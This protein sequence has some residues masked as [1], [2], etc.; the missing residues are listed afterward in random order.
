MVGAVEKLALLAFGE[1][2][3]RCRDA[4]IEVLGDSVEPRSVVRAVV[5]PGLED[6]FDRFRG[7][8]ND[9]ILVD[10]LGLAEALTLR[11]GPMRAVKR[12]ASGLDFGKLKVAV[13][14]AKGGRKLEDEPVFTTVTRLAECARR[15][16]VR[17]EL[18]VGRRVGNNDFE[19]AVGLL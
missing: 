15:T 19:C 2:L 12:E 11:A 6:V 14:V 13:G 1:L 3:E 17:I 7:I 10:F 9:E 5:T 4:H 18:E 16:D 8:D